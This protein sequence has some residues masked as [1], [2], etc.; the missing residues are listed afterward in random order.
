MRSGDPSEVS[1][2]TGET[3]QDMMRRHAMERASFASGGE[4]T[5]PKLQQSHLE[6]DESDSLV[7]EIMKGRQRKKMADG[8]QVDLE[9]NSEEDLN[10]EDQMS[11]QAGGKE[12]Y[13]LRQLNKQPM[14]SN[15]DGDSREE[16]EENINDKSDVEQI[17]RKMKAKSGR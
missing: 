2:H 9:G 8:G 14:D 4:V 16:D 12:Q 7:Q 15:E 5:N 6:P 3:E 17:R 1:P 11:Y 10:N 13:D